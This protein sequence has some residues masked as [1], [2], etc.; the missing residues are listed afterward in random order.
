MSYLSVVTKFG[1]MGANAMLL[2]SNP[3][4]FSSSVRIGRALNM[5]NINMNSLYY[6]WENG[7]DFTNV[8]KKGAKICNSAIYS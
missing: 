4:G 7:L 1:V 6:Y 2:F 3:M 5:F 8:E